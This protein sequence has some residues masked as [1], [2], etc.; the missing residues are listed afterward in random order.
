M[1]GMDNMDTNDRLLWTEWTF[2]GDIFAPVI[3][4]SNGKSIASILPMMSI[5]VHC[6]SNVICRLNIVCASPRQAS[7]LKELH[8]TDDQGA[9]PPPLGSN[10]RNTRIFR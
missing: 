6:P 5:R 9:T 1:D 3:R 7:L 8:R 10:N 4:P 2:T